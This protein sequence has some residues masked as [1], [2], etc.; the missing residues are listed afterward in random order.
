[1]P[2]FETQ[3]ETHVAAAPATLHATLNDLRTWHT[4][5]PWE[6]LDP[7]LKRTFSGPETG[8]GSHYAWVGNK[9]VGEGSMEITG[10]TPE[11]IDIDLEFLK[12]FKASNKV[13]F[14][15]H[16]EGDGTRVVW[17]MSGERNLA[18]TVMGKLFFDKAIAKDFDKG[19]A[20]L[21][22]TLEA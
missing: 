7:Q 21:K 19:L 22:A 10:S 6:E 15:L 3:R 1:M 14:E 2:H 18:F 5:S 8:I 4:W 12:P 17:A 16:P 11:Q 20:K 13:V 9:K